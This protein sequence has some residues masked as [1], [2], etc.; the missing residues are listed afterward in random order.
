MSVICAQNVTRRFGDRVAIDALS[1]RIEPGEV[2]ALLGPNGAGKTTTIE[3]LEGFLA[4]T[5]GS[6]SVLGVDPRRGDRR[7]RAR[8]GL[9]LQSTSLDAQLCVRDALGV[10]SSLFPRP[11]PVAEVLELVGLEQEADTR[12]G[13][14]SGGQQRR[15][16]LGLGIVGRPEVLFLDE[17]TTGLDPAARRSTWAAIEQLAADGTTVLLSTHYLEEAQRL[18]GRLLVL[19]D[20]GLV[21]DATPGGLRASALRSTVRLPSSTGDALADLPPVLRHHIDPG[22]SELVIRTAD[23]NGVLAALLD[24]AHEH[25]VCLDGLE[26]GP[27]SLEDVYLTLTADAA[28]ARAVSHA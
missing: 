22:R 10:F 27:P 28:D 18:A 4:P 2:V 12:I 6:V 5:D 21:A 23:V 20:G 17:P 7:W 16:D 8:I 1:F 24:W 13:R 19:R 15:I 14:L 25:D 9:V 26:V 11:R 3:M